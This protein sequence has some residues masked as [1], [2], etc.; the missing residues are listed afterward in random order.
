VDGGGGG[1]FEAGRSGSSEWWRRGRRE[2]DENGIVRP[3]WMAHVDREK[4]SGKPERVKIPIH[5]LCL[6]GT[7]HIATNFCRIFLSEP[8]ER[9]RKKKYR[10][11]TI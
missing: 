4:H 5:F 6:S 7:N 11:G 10:L 2:R 3:L 1:G 8:L 9:A